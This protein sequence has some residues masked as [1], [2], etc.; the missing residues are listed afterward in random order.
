MNQVSNPAAL[1]GWVKSVDPNSGRVFFANHITR[2]TQWEAP[3]GWIEEPSPPLM[4]PVGDDNEDEPLPD[5]WDVMHDPSTG[6]AFYVDHA[7]QITQWTRPRNEIKPQR[8][9][10]YAPA[11]TSNNS[12]ALARILKAT[13]LGTRTSSDS[14]HNQRSYSQEAAYFHHT[15]SGSSDVDFSDSLPSLDFSVKKVADKYRL[16][17]PHCDALFTISKRRHHCRLCGDVFCDTCSNHRVTLPLQGPEFEKPVRICDFC[18]KDV[19]QGNFFSM[20]RYLTPLQ[21]YDPDLNDDDDNGV[22][23]SANVNAAL[24]ALTDDLNQIVH[25]SEGFDEKVSIPPKILVPAIAKHLNSKSNT[26]DR[27]VRALASLLSM[28]SMVGKTDYAKAVYGH[29]GRQTIDRILSILERS[30]SDRRTLFVQEQAAQSLFYLTDKE[31]TDS[32]T[33]NGSRS[34]DEGETASADSL[35]LS[36]TFQNVLDHA[37]SS[38]NPNLQRWSAAIVRNLIILD[39]RRACMAINTVASKAASGEAAGLEY[40]S[41]LDQFVSSGGIMILCSLI[42]AEDSDTRAHA[43]GAL[44]S[45]LLSTRSID[46]AMTALSEMTGGSLGRTN[47]KDGEIVRAITGSGGCGSSV[48]Q[49]LLSADNTLAAMGCDFVASLV[50]P[51]LTNPGGS[52]TLP[53][54]YECERDVDG[55]GACREAALEIA[56]GSCLPALMSLVRENGRTPRPIEL[57]RRGMEC[58]SATVLAVGSIG[59]AWAS[60]AYEE[61][62]DANEAPIAVTKAISMLNSEDVVGMALDM[63]NSTSFQSLGSARDTPSARILE[64]GGIILGALSSCSAETIMDLHSRK[65]LPALIKGSNDSSMTAAS[66]IRGDSAPRCLGLLE[67]TSSVLLFAWQHPSGAASELLD[68]LIEVLDSGAI[69]HLTRILTARMDWESRDKSA[70]SM[71]ARAA[72]CRIL[73]CLFGIAQVDSTG[74][75]MRRLVEACDTEQIRPRNGKG[76]RNIME[77]VLTVMQ[78]ALSYC[79][80]TLIGGSNRGPHYQSALADLVDS[81]LLAAGSMC[82]SSVAPGGGEGIGGDAFLGERTADEFEPR[83]REVCKVA[84]DIVVR[85]ARTGPSFLPTLLV[86]GFGEESVMSSLRLALAVAQNGNATEHSKL[87]SSGIIVPVS[88]L[89]RTALSKGDLYKF[90]AA[91]ALVRFCGPH[92]AASKSG[93]I[94][95][96]RDALRVATNVLSLPSNP[97]AN[98]QQIRTQ[99]ALKAECMSAIESLSKNSSLWS[100]ISTDAL[101]AITSFL[102]NCDN[103]PEGVPQLDAQGAALRA[104]LQIV[105]V[106]SHAVAAAESGIWMAVGK[107]LKTTGISNQ[108]FGRGD[109]DIRVLAVEVLH[110]LS[111][112]GEARKHFKLYE[113]DLLQSV[114]AVVGCINGFAA[115]DAQAIA[116]QGLEILQLALSDV[117]SLGDGAEV[118]QSPGAT[119]FMNSVTS[120]PS[121]VHLL[122]ATL[123]CSR[124]LKTNIAHANASLDAFGTPLP[125]SSSKCL[126]YNSTK[127][128][129]LA[130][131]FSVS[132][133]ACAIESQRSDSF[134][135]SA[136][137]QDAQRSE[138]GLESVRA[139]TYFSLT[140]LA[141]LGSEAAIHPHDKEKQQDFESLTRPLVR[142]RLLEALKDLIVEATSESA[143]GHQELDEGVRSLLVAYNLPHMC[144]S[145]CMDPGL[146]ELAYEL[147]KVV[148][149]ADGEDFLPLFVQDK[150]CILSLL[151]LLVVETDAG[152]LPIEFRRFLVS[153]MEKLAQEGLLAEAVEKYNIRSEA[154]SALAVACLSEDMGSTTDDAELSSNKLAHG[155][156]HCLVDLCSPPGAKHMGTS[157]ELSA[158]EAETIATNLGKKMCQMVISRFLERARYQEYDIEEHE[159]VLDAPEIKMLLGC[160]KHET[161]LRVLQSLGG[162]HALAQVASEGELP[163]LDALRRGCARDPT[164]LIDADTHSS[165]IHLFGGDESRLSW[166]GDSSRRSKLES[167]AFQLLSLLGRESAKGRLA[168][169][170]VDGYELCHARAIEIVSGLGGSFLD[171]KKGPLEDRNDDDTEN[172]GN[173]SEGHA[174]N[175]SVET[176]QDQLREVDNVKRG[177][178]SAVSLAFSRMDE[179]DSELVQAALEYL[180]SMISVPE[181]RCSI[182]QCECFLD[183]LPYLGAEDATHSLQ[184]ESVRIISGLVRYAGSTDRKFKPDLA[185]RLLISALKRQVPEGIAVC[186]QAANG[187]QF[188]FDDLGQDLQRT[189][190]ALTASLLAKVLKGQALVRTSNRSDDSA[191]GGVLAYQLTTLLLLSNGKESVQE[192]FDWN[193][194]TTLVNV[195]QWRYDPKTEVKESQICYWDAATTQALQIISLRIKNGELLLRAPSVTS[196]SDLKSC[197]YMV[198][199][200]GRAPRKAIDL[201]SAL[202]LIVKSG[203][204]ASKLAAL[205]IA[206][207]LEEDESQGQLW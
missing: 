130:L 70:G 100:A 159:D 105:Q 66:T 68:R 131:L 151:S 31:T 158:V 78:S 57:R 134:W 194:I 148:I 73:C 197:V 58:L 156:M 175:D 193:V 89:L 18:N 3:E 7:R 10:S 20:R 43:T 162:M 121:F 147:V 188:V 8:T 202:G 47:K 139:A 173:G 204:P 72:A 59:K 81:S 206:K 21:L 27:A 124:G 52:V 29:G 112:N 50:E 144:L 126:G 170:Q 74:I 200:A 127:E 153:T 146:L 99:E 143:M 160:A 87:A 117:E 174:S 69:G 53:P 199:R 88:D 49:L 82:G 187:V 205:S 39:Q 2:K 63:L 122:C 182:L 97:D 1:Q 24:A 15:H 95:S 132:S 26:A 114:C 22:A 9:I 64:A 11:S 19:E 38:K 167:A 157:I 94:E 116:C 28:G 185:G 177:V 133:F 184:L 71:K 32:L 181:V 189:A 137:L 125:A 180:S 33:R 195:V 54:L 61:G 118:L 62:M 13:S 207:C 123:V 110:I 40:E 152:E 107:I 172:S 141:Y 65:V 92:V 56:S 190:I 77:A 79:N 111:M 34:E 113:S 84:C 104:V 154:V 150:E 4:P 135:A 142:Y 25:G 83:R 6:K 186:I 36:R 90:S 102:L 198:S 101:P 138:T 35:D 145:V 203:D 166:R 136:L 85:G 165:I 108:L 75:G 48:S 60:G 96:I 149:D 17:C 178:S 176:P 12:A 103:A 37:S 192:C 168:I 119:S 5:N 67:T 55:L 16:E 191:Q 109:T 179:N 163:A 42:G 41:F 201:C 129:A 86:G 14:D 120:E 161:A 115:E 140:F 164:M 155:L 80:K 98:P 196:L 51:L 169:K 91:L 106:P 45:I 183:V 23:T 44:G 30:G 76:P 46:D 93:G 171:S 128:A